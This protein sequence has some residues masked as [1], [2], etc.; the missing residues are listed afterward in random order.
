MHRRTTN[1]ID[2][3]LITCELCGIPIVY[4][5]GMNVEDLQGFR[6]FFEDEYSVLCE[7]CEDLVS[8]VNEEVV[9]ETLQ[10]GY[11]S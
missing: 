3:D 10:E 11:L 4:F 7:G 1:I 8:E 9:N 2:Q 5:P 6:E